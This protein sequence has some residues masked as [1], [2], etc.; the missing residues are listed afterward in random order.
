MGGFDPVQEV[1]NL[2]SSI[3]DRII[4]PALNDPLETAAV[5]AAAAIGGPVAA[6]ATK[7]AFALDEGKEFEDAL[8]EGATVAATTYVGQELTGGSDYN[9]D[10][11]AQTGGFYG[12]SSAPIYE[13]TAVPASEAA[14]PSVEVG[15][16]STPVP[17]SLTEYL[18]NTGTI[19]VEGG[20]TAVA[21]TFEAAI[22]ELTSAAAAPSLLS[23]KNALDSARLAN[24][25]FGGKQQQQPQMPFQPQAYQPGVV[26]Y[27]NYLSLLAMR[28]QRRTTSLI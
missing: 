11:E 24:Q 4:Q 21:G 6:G 16:T 10:A 9:Y 19:P 13:A 1:K 23:V 27:S 15:P 5:I 22:P 18:Q 28:P 14:Y 7:T 8:K 20:A 17:G 12:E 26:D 25:L 2:G 3:D